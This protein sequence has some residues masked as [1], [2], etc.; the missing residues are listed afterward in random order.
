MVDVIFVD[1]FGRRTLSRGSPVLTSLI[2]VLGELVPL[3][4]IGIEKPYHFSQKPVLRPLIPREES[5]SQITYGIESL[6]D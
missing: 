2:E 6:T 3:D 5:Q 1:L 4:V